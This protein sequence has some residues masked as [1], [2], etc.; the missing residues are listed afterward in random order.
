MK[1]VQWQLA[2]IKSEEEFQDL[3]QSTLSFPHYYGRNRDAFWDC[4]NEV[5]ENTIVRVSGL[6]TLPDTLKTEVGNYIRMAKEYEKK[7]DGLFKL[8]LE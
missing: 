8:T 5:V 7:T 2:R 6:G 1:E 3:V 4:L